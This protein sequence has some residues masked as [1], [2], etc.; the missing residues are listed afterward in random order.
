[1]SGNTTAN[2]TGLQRAE[3]YSSVIL[4]ELHDDFLPEGLARDVS[5]FPDGSKLMIPTFGEAVIKDVVEGQETPINTIDTGRIELE[6]TEHKGTGISMTDEMKEDGFYVDQFNAA[7]PGKMLHALKEVYETDLLM[8]GEFGQ[9][10]GDANAINGFAH[11]W[12]ASGAD[13]RIGLAD[14]S[15]AKT[16]FLKAKAPDSGIICILD[17]ISELSL[18]R[19]SNIANV[20]NNP[21]FEGIVETGFGKGMRFMKNIFGVDVWMS[22]RLPRIAA[23]TIDTTANDG[24][25]APLGETGVQTGALSITDGYAAQFMIVSDDMTTPYM[26][27]WRRKPAVEFFRDVPHRQD[28]FY[29][30]TRYGFAMQRPQT[31]ATCLVAADKY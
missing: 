5:D 30:T 31:L 15:Y 17:P 26:S 29:I 1:M 3:V 24:V 21:H 7:A 20:S 11:R 23:E 8:T 9:T 18:N 4:D 10:Q 6:I 27:A 25:P 28:L 14:F 22:N 19:L 12:V 13:Q 16:A 2:T